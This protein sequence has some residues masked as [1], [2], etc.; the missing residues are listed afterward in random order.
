MLDDNTLPGWE[1]SRDHYDHLSIDYRDDIQDFKMYVIYLEI[2]FVIISG[3][4]HAKI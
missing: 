3:V 2:N 1:G 4:N